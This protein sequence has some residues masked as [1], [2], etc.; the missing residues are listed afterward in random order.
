MLKMF[1]PLFTPILLSFRILT[2]KETTL[3]GKRSN[4]FQKRQA[5]SKR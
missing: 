4:H 5:Q 2:A 3:Y 1:T